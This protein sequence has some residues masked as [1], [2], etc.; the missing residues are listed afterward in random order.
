M[1][2][3]VSVHSVFCFTLLFECVLQGN[4]GRAGEGAGL[5]MAVVGAWGLRWCLRHV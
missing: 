2:L 1:E 5:F 3:S 4:V